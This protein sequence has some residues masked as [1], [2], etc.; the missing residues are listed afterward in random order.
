MYWQVNRETQNTYMGNDAD[1]ASEQKKKKK[2]KKTVQ[3]KHF[4]TDIGKIKGATTE[5]VLDSRLWAAAWR[6]WE[7]N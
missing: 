1:V 3:R 7:D 4:K 6:P 2:K 5:Q